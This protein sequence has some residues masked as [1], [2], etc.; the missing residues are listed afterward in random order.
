MTIPKR[1]DPATLTPDD[2]T[3]LLDAAVSAWKSAG[4][5]KKKVWFQWGDWSF[6][7]ILTRFTIQVNTPTGDLI[8]ERFGSPDD[9]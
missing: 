9:F 1:L 3:D 8:A 4:P 2:I 7:S 5:K 6:V